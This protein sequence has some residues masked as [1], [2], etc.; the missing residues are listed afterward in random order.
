MNRHVWNIPEVSSPDNTR[1]SELARPRIRLRDVAEEAG[2]S[3]SLVYQVA[4]GRKRPNAAIRAAVE[5]LF[6][7]PAWAVFGDSEARPYRKGP[8]P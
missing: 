8:A 4:R 7:V 3:L 5:R 6:G 2:V 1:L